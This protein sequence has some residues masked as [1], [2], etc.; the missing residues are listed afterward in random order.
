MN[1]PV[2]RLEALLERIQRNRT[3]PRTRARV[4]APAAREELE[5]RGGAAPAPRTPTPVPPRAPSPPPAQLEVVDEEEDM[6]EEP[7][8]MPP[9][10]VSK[11]DDWSDEPTKEQAAAPLMLD[12]LAA[13]AKP[14]PKLELDTEAA[15]PPA[16]Q[17]L[18]LEPEPPTARKRAPSQDLEVIIE[19]PAEGPADEDDELLFDE[20]VEGASL[21]PPS[22][23]SAP[24]SVAPSPPVAA[25]PPVIEA[26]PPAR[27]VSPAEVAP[28]AAVAAAPVAQ[29][30]ARP[31]S[32]PPEPVADHIVA[33]PLAST[34]P[35]VRT[36]GQVSVRP[37]TF[38]A[39][40][41][42]ALS[43]RPR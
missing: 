3:L 12:E 36:V 5:T 34:G 35:V 43:L 19:E 6:L 20:P 31:S 32:V 22:Q 11:R 33:P 29:P 37:A 8:T 21:P 30:A 9:P 1:G 23:E 42:R 27:V 38:G 39:L 13:A 28:A 26:T 18:K 25:S 15:H 40:I 14:A 2:Q 7:A 16:K 17:P 4:G 24:P 10:A 41:H